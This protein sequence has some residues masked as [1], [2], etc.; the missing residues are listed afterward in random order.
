M[1]RFVYTG[2][3]DSYDSASAGRV[4]DNNTPVDRRIASRNLYARSKASCEAILREQADKDGLR[5]VIARPGIVIGPGSPLAHP[6]VGRFASETDVRFWGDGTNKLPLV[7]VDD[8]ADALLKAGF[9]PDIDGQ[10]LLV[11]GPPLL[12]AREYVAAYEASAGIQIAAEPGSLV[13]FWLADLVKESAK[14]LIRHPN[15]RRST[16]HDWECRSH[17]ARYDPAQTEAVL[18]WHPIADPAV[19]RARAIDALVA[20]D[21]R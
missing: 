19:L 17:R 3:I 14:N 6:G 16:L 4:I 15:R 8:V 10:T 2:T 20:D 11:C 1:Q 7:H 9:V 18:D 21:A 12:S 5:L 13:R